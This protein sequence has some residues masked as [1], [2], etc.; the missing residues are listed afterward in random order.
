MV[1]VEGEYCTEQFAPHSQ[2]ASNLVADFTH[3]CIAAQTK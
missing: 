1:A 3:F 2:N